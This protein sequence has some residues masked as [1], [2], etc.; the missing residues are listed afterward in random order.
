MLFYVNLLLV[1]HIV[2]I[3]SACSGLQNTR[4]CSCTTSYSFG[5][6]NQSNSLLL[7]IKSYDDCGI[8]LGCEKVNDCS[9]YCFR[10]T[11]ELLGSDPN[12]VTQIAQD[13]LCSLIAVNQ[14]ITGMDN[15]INVWVNWQYSNCKTGIN[16]IISS[17]CC[18]KRCICDMI[19]QT[20]I[21]KIDLLIEFTKEMAPKPIAYDCAESEFDE[22][23]KE[24]RILVGNK[25]K[26]EEIKE[27]TNKLIPNYNL[28]QVSYPDY[29]QTSD[30]S[31]S[32]LMCKIL[33]RKVET[34]G[35]EI[36]VKIA[37]DN[38]FFKNL[39][40]YLPVGRLCC[41]QEC[42][43]EIFSQTAN[44]L[45]ESGKDKSLKFEDITNIVDSDVRNFSYDCFNTK[46]SCMKYCRNALGQYLQSDLIMKNATASNWI[47]TDLDV[48]SENTPGTRL[49]QKL[50]TNVAP[51]GLNFYLRSNTGSADFPYTDDLHIGRL[52]CFPFMG[53]FVP[54]NR[55]YNFP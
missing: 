53:R 36:F 55:C 33:N 35:Y 37:T 6:Q 13:K 23:E 49:C 45:T 39:G 52:C 30:D 11:K 42:K 29:Q 40:K 41:K 44:F 47:T 19:G 2:N 51:P 54:F 22:C 32:E 10:K 15:G 16:Q 31:A 3:A 50:Q 38:L 28:F 24:C 7:P 17:L 4:T 25:F 26:N 9:Q 12:Q 43:C 14:S 1:S 8:N 34:P 18:R 20:K 27:F 48:F 46:Q 5:S 21:N